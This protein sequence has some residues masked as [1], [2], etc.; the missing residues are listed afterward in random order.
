MRPQG[1]PE[2]G[3]ASSGGTPLEKQQ[4]QRLPHVHFSRRGS[5]HDRCVQRFHSG[6][7]PL[8]A[9][10]ALDRRVRKGVPDGDV[11][12]DELECRLEVDDPRT[13]ASTAPVVREIKTTAVSISD[14][15]RELFQK[16]IPTPAVFADALHHTGAEYPAQLPLFHP[17]EEVGP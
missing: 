8:P 16:I 9:N 11:S 4:A 7:N 2:A 10:A 12:R 5:G 17:G 1:G 13:P 3:T 6:T 14:K 15:V